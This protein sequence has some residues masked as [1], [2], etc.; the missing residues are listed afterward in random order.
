MLMSGILTIRIFF[1]TI[2]ILLIN[3]VTFSNHE[4]GSSRVR[5]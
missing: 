5:V 3:V 2:R 4:I 1:L